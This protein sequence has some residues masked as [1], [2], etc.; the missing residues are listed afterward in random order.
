LLADY[1]D[2]PCWSPLGDEIAAQDHGIIVISY[3]DGD[4]ATIPC[5]DPL[6][7]GCE[8]ECPTW[9]PD[10]EWLAFEDGLEILK[11]PRSGGTATPVVEGL[12]DVS[13]P[14]WSPDGKW[15][16]FMM[17]SSDYQCAHIW[18]TDY[19]GTDQGLYQVT[20]GEY[21]DHS[22]AWSPDSK[23]I[24][25]NRNSVDSAHYTTPLGIWRVS[26]SSD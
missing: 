24:Y 16:A 20:S 21:F 26:F 12:R 17:D 14:A 18:V 4:T 8:G 23:Y 22:P 15:I 25:F 1:D 6:D 11:V 5:T 7:G 19:R 2:G 13:Y 3:P 9:S 10:G